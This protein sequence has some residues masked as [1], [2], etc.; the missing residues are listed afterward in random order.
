MEKLRVCQ[1]IWLEENNL[2]IQVPRCCPPASTQFQANMHT[3]FSPPDLLTHASGWIC[4]PW[5]P[6]C[7]FTYSEAV[8]ASEISIRLEF[9]LAEEEEWW[10]RARRRLPRAHRILRSAREPQS[11]T[12]FFCTSQFFPAAGNQG[13]GNA[14]AWD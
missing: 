3:P 10:A 14:R 11:A 2:S 12:S 13:L 4:R 5:R 1:I 7:T 6:S 9:L 8:G